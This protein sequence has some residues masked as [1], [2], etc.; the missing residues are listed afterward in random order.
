MTVQPSI[1]AFAGSAR[2]GSFNK[3]VVSIAARAAEQAGAKVTVIDLADYPLPLFDQDLEA[4]AGPPENAVKLLELLKSHPGLLIASPEYNSSIAPLLKNMIDWTSRRIG[5]NTPLAGF[6]G[7]AAAIMSASPGALGGLR[8]LVHLR[9]I[10][11]NIG[12]LVLPEQVAVMQA[13]KALDDQG[14]LR[15]AKLQANVEKL[16]TRLAQ[17]LSKLHA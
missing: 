1:L 7:K 13:D 12:V 16:G 10:L 2:R 14:Q 17:V 4:A 3:Q 5:D 15:D 9:S 6:H 8:G 11:G